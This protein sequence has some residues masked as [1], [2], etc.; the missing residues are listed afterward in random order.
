MHQNGNARERERERVQT[1]KNPDKN[2]SNPTRRV[3]KTKSYHCWSRLQVSKKWK[4]QS[5]IEVEE[6]QE[7]Q[8][9]KKKEKRRIRRRGWEEEEEE[10]SKEWP[11]ALLYEKVKKERKKKEKKS[12]RKSLQTWLIC[13]PS[14]RLEINL[15]FANCIIVTPSLQVGPSSVTPRAVP[16]STV[17]IYSG[18]RTHARMRAL[19]HIFGPY[20]VFIFFILT[21]FYSGD[22][23]LA[24]VVL[25]T[26]FYP[27]IPFVFLLLTNMPPPE[28]IL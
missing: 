13:L 22:C 24:G 25:L 18:D 28:T 6:L 26:L 21:L 7:E 23:C 20:V 3:I 17:P 5:R 14:Q 12:E 27:K 10:E 8:K 9:K 4:R 15:F 16:T 11:L 1:T 19:G 2:K